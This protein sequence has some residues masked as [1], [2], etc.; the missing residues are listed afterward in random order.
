MS[1]PIADMLTRIRNGQQ[2]KKTEVSMPG[3]KLK[4]AIASVLKDE[5]YITDFSSGE[6]MASRC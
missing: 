1:D 5:G 3:S 2:A 6:V 4:A